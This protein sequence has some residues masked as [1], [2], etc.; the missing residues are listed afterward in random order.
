[1]ISER[2]K[3]IGDVIEAQGRDIPDRV[4]IVFNEERYAYGQILDRANRLS[5]ALIDLGVNKGDKVAVLAQNIPEYPIIY[6]AIARIGAVYV[7]VNV[8][9]KSEE[10]RYVVEQSD[11]TAVLVTSQL[12][13]EYA[14]IR[15]E[16]KNVKA[17][18]LIN[19]GAE[20]EKISEVASPKREGE[21]GLAPKETFD[22]L[23]LFDD[24]MNQYPAKKPEVAVSPEDEHVFW[25]TS[26]TTGFPKAAVLTHE[27]SL[28]ATKSITS[29][30]GLTDK[31]IALIMLPLFHN[32]Y[33][34]ACFGPHMLGGTA[35]ILESFKPERAFEEIQ[36]NR[37][38]L[39]FGVP[40]VYTLLLD[41]RTRQ[42]F[43]LSSIKKIVFGASLMS[44]ETIRRLQETFNCRLYHAYGQSEHCPGISVL[45][46]EYLLRKPDSIGTPM[47]N[48]IAIMDDDNNMLPPNTT[49][50]IC[51]RGKGM[52]KGYY[53]K[54]KETAKVIQDGWLHTNDMGYMDEDG[55]LYI[56]GRKD[57]MI[58]R[59]GE[60][61]HPKDIED[62]LY[63]FDKVR[64]A[65]VIGVP[66]SVMG[67]AVKAFV[68][69]KEG[70]ESSEEEI[71]AFCDKKIA[72][73]KIPRYVEI[74]HE[75]PMNPSGK[76]LKTVLKD[77]EITRYKEVGADVYEG[78]K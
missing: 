33:Q 13:P 61:I 7:P 14:H 66:D 17:S 27:A 37:A 49:G 25:Y 42:T 62:L 34:C 18:I 30:I 60:N 4:A 29:A 71:R 46:N 67:E 11:S 5:N 6:F 56:Q 12:L 74:C 26:G 44:P 32:I 16:L 78:K 50:E 55:F 65:T 63:S 35:V 53:N 3:V 77:R 23:I 10:V 20:T 75:F 47:N 52:M 39:L 1:M 54:P 36:R 22:G 51:C 28:F 73:F 69:L 31:D 40:A 76:V 58:N 15:S 45:R 2:Y 21:A 64:D 72:N 41:Q 24:L 68:I 38:T 19:R 9:F 43:D 48:E 57:D 59:G 8:H 70:Q